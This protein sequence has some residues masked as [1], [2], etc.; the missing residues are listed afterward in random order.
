MKATFL[1][2]T[3]MNTFELS[4]GAW[5]KGIMMVTDI[6][7]LFFFLTI[8]CAQHFKNSCKLKLCQIIDFSKPNRVK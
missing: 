8:D 2:S 7:L 5:G 4:H 6:I 1:E 3:Q